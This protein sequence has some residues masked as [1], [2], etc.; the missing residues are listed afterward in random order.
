MEI[1]SDHL[2]GDD[3]DA[4]AFAAA[5]R[6]YIRESIIEQRIAERQLIADMIKSG[7]KVDDLIATAQ[8]PAAHSLGAQALHDRPKR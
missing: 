8:K 4:C 6:E 5:E 3:S 1:D 7:V 2:A